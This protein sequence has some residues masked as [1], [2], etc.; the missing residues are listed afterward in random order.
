MSKYKY[1]VIDT[2]EVIYAD[3]GDEFERKWNET[4]S[5]PC[6]SNIKLTNTETGY[7]NMMYHIEVLF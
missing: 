6:K 3:S 2:G 5:E 4:H 7:E 1:E